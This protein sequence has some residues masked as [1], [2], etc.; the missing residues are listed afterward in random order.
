MA[1]GEFQ[2][3]EHD[4]KSGQKDR[5]RIGSVAGMVNL[6]PDVVRVEELADG[7]LVEGLRPGTATIRVWDSRGGR[8]VRVRVA[9]ARPMSRPTEGHVHGTGPGLSLRGGTHAFAWGGPPGT[10]VIL[11]QDAGAAWEGTRSRAAGEA[12]VEFREGEPR[13]PHALVTLEAKGSPSTSVELGTA[14]LAWSPYTFFRER[15]AGGRMGLALPKAT[16]APGWSLEAALGADAPDF[17]YMGS[18]LG[19]LGATG[20]GRGG[21]RAQW[22]PS[23]SVVTH[24]EIG[25]AESSEGAVGAVGAVGARGSM[26]ALDVEGLVGFDGSRIAMRGKARAELFETVARVSGEVRQSGFTNLRSGM[27]RYGSRHFG[28]GLSRDF[29]DR[30]SLT[31]TTSRSW[32]GLPEIEGEAAAIDMGN[33]GLTGT[34]SLGTHAALATDLRLTLQDMPRAHWRRWRGGLSFAVRNVDLPGGAKLGGRLSVADQRDRARGGIEGDYAWEEV[35]LAPAVRVTDWLGVDGAVALRLSDPDATES[36]RTWTWEGRLVAR[37]PAPK[38]FV[39]SRFA[40]GYREWEVLSTGTGRFVRGS[41]LTAS[42]SLKTRSWRGF[43]LESDGSWTYDPLGARGTG[44]IHGALVYGASARST[45][46][47]HALSP[48]RGRVRGLVFHDADGDGE[49]DRDEVGLA[50]ARVRLD[51]GREAVTRPNGSFSLRVS[52]GSKGQVRVVD[53]YD[54]ALEPTTPEVQ[55]PL[56]FG[57]GPKPA[58]LEVL[59]FNDLD[60]NGQYGADEPLVPG[61]VLRMEGESLPHWQD[62]VL[63]TRGATPLRR[64]LP[65][66][67]EV[68]GEWAVDAL[69]TGYQP[70]DVRPLSV[71][72]GP[73]ETVRWTLALTARR[74]IEGRVYLDA[75][76]NGGR[77][78]VEGVVVRA[79]TRHAI[80]DASGRY[81]LLG[82]PYGMVEVTVMEGAPEGW[83]APPPVPVELGPVPAQVRGID[84]ALHAEVD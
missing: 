19:P 46:G 14:T 71:R 79:G 62:R 1:P 21:L 11:T 72:P 64:V 44:A 15:I 76:G 73:D 60:G 75:N 38:L 2:L 37:V 67:S 22:H 26:P 84:L 30:L 13:L 34:V 28:A 29:G 43:F 52:R 61:V 7:I 48:M 41:H 20:G 25:I 6:D 77:P 65:S 24:A 69:P 57:L 9:A 10:S 5:L 12:W 47:P 3:V 18:R 49:R 56:L 16:G 70:V 81:V 59:A 83:T 40:L 36:P 58:T 66:G 74:T 51:D 33:H 55:I 54:P 4:L 35:R 78:G 68:R 63:R 32:S 53:G 80:S 17:V 23:E 31:A 39:S 50:G 27:H 8:V 45:P 82:L 42:L